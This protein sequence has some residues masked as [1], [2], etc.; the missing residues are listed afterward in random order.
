VTRSQGLR[1]PRRGRL[2]RPAGTRIRWS[3]TG[4][5]DFH[6]PSCGGDRRYLRRE[7]LLRWTLLG[8]P[9]LPRGRTGPVLEC[10][11]CAGHFDVAAL[12]TPTA[13]RLTAMLQE[14]VRTL[15]LA[16]LA[17]GGADNACVRGAAAEALREAG[18]ADCTASATGG[19]EVLC[20]IELHE[21]LAPLAL[22]LAPEGRERLL[23]TGARVALAD[24]LYRAAERDLLAA[25]GVALRLGTET[26]HR[27]LAEAA[28]TPF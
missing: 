18:R 8:V 19:D 23:L 13:T 17:T 25:A 4:D 3:T 15:V 5:G 7:G 22:H 14:A 28:R 10:A 12:K 16:V 21:A 2:P 26:T 27:L 24:G 1:T 20:R 11:G 6:C 9:L